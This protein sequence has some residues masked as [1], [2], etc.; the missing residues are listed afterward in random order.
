M[1]YSKEQYEQLINGAKLFR[2]D[3]TKDSELWKTEARKLLLLTIEYYRDYI[4]KKDTFEN[5]GLELIEGI[6]QSIRAFSP[7][8]GVFLHYANVAIKRRI[9]QK[10]LSDALDRQRRGLS[11]SEKDNQLIKKMLAYVRSKGYDINDAKTQERIAYQF[12][13]SIEQVQIC[14]AQS[15]ITVIDETIS[16]SDGERSS[17]FDGIASN[18]PN[19]EQQ[20]E[21]N[22]NQLEIIRRVDA[23]FQ[24]CQERQK[25]LLSY[26]L[27][28]R[29]I[30]EMDL[31][32]YILEQLERISF[33]DIE[34]LKEYIASGKMPSARQIAI[35]FEL[36]EQSASRTLKTFFEKVPRKG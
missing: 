15:Q 17:I 7:E 1:G 5:F 9:S 19:A 23:V 32:E 20:M 18:R 26:L 33:V 31:N 35:E 21:Q 28:A 29:L 22:E 12:H 25:S 3:R 4:L 8:K 2:I 36:T 14:V 6:K 27:T 11:V 30:P 16:N 24:T 10:K 34:L 13:L